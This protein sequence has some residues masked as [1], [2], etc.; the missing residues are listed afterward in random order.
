MKRLNFKSVV[1]IIVISIV[2]SFAAYAQ[3]TLPKVY[4]I[5]LKQLEETWNVL[6]QVSGKVWP[7]WTKYAEVPFLFRYA[8]GVQMLVGHPNP[9]DGFKLVEGVTV[10][11]KKVYLNKK[12]E[13]P[14]E[15]I[16]PVS[17]GG[18]P[19]PYGSDGGKSVLVVDLTMSGK[20]NEVKAE[21]N[22][23]G[24]AGRQIY[25]SE[26]Q[27]LINL[28]ELFHCY[29]RDVYR[30]RYGNLQ[31]NT[32]ANYAVYAEIE[33]IALER[34]YIAKDENKAKEYMK[35]FI[36]ARELK[37]NS[38]D[39]IERMQ[40]A[41]EE[42]MEGG[43]VHAEVRTCEV[44][45]EGF[46]PG[47]SGS[48]DPHYMKFASVDSLIADK[49][50]MLRNSRVYTMDARNKSYSYGAFQ[51]LL[52][53]RFT[54]GW[55]NGFYQKKFFFD[56]LIKEYL[57]ISDGEKETIEN[58]LKTDYDYGNIYAKHKKIVDERDNAYKLVESRKGLSFIINFKNT[59][60]Y[61]HLTAKKKFSLGLIN[62]YPEG[63]EKL[64][65]EDVE[66]TGNSSPVIL[67]QLYYVKWID[68]NSKTPAD[69]YKLTYDKKE[70]SDIYCNAVITTGGFTLKAPKIQITERQGRIKITILSKIKS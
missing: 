6:D 1:T 35:D 36:V 25:E 9:P 62:I 67:D 50:S 51:A 53:D 39:E 48:D 3:E 45:K 40:E 2:F 18:G 38:M 21:E 47:I 20:K 70:G 46:K 68:T 64:K 26:N 27:L 30:W 41:E 8:N 61:P 63:F 13:I 15:M 44:I 65:M 57:K 33:G 24:S 58:R 17:G 59:Y 60:E 7:G 32:D 12:E 11:N 22:P 19:I 14:L 56:Q 4:S 29:Q 34:A 28:H 52:L 54:P 66:L 10:R 16:L 49:L 5:T 37:H 23:S 55:Q 42:I 31:Y 43:A 69:S